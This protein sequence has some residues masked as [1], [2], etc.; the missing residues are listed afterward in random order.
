MWFHKMTHQQSVFKIISSVV[1][2]TASLTNEL[3]FAFSLF[4]DRLKEHNVK[5]ANVDCKMVFASKPI[6]DRLKV[7]FGSA[8][9][10]I[11]KM[12][13]LPV[14]PETTSAVADCPNRGGF[15]S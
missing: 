9:P 12:V 3:A 15:A 11:T 7:C 13:H 1:A 8:L 14:S 6:I 4:A 10:D 5:K 2:Q